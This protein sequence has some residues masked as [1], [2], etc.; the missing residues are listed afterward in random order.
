MGENSA[1]IVLPGD[2]VTEVGLKAGMG[3]YKRGDRVF[4]SVTGVKSV[5]SG[6]VNVSPFS[7][8]YMPRPGDSVVGIVADA[9]SSSWFVDI[10]SPYN[11]P[12]HVSEVPWRVEFGE[13]AQFLRS[14]DAI[15]AKITGVDELKRTQLTLKEAGLRKLAG[16]QII[17]IPHTK[18][19]RVIGRAGGVISVLK[20]E[21]G[22]RMFVG[23]N[24]RIWIDGEVEAILRVEKAISMITAGMG[25]GSAEDVRALLAKD[26]GD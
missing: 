26:G 9:G 14:G 4:A 20:Q 25:Y 16:G 6:Y 10:N 8:R 18:V 22:C 11:A 1:S 21:T 23:Q 12:L 3:T 5:R 2:D 7:G 13:T 19:P 17:N 15:L 24:G